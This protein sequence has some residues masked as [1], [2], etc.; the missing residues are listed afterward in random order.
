MPETFPISSTPVASPSHGLYNSYDA[1]RH[2]PLPPQ[3]S[4]SERQP[5]QQDLLQPGSLENGEIAR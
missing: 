1:D 3:T 5:E 4:I 2:E